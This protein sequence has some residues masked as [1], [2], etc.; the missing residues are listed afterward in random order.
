MDKKIEEFIE[1]ELRENPDKLNKDVE[2]LVRI[3]EKYN[4]TATELMALSLLIQ[5]IGY[6]RNSKT[7][8]LL[9]AVAEIIESPLETRDTI[10]AR[11]NG[12]LQ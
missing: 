8:N 6:G 5:S 9:R 7:A 10:E 3:R 1:K 4:V 11:M 12:K 2:I